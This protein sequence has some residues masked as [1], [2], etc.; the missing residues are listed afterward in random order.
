MAN[1]SNDKLFMIKFFGNMKVF[2]TFHLSPIGRL[3]EYNEKFKEYL[4]NIM[5]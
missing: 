2:N 4:G 1:Y 5:V 3:V